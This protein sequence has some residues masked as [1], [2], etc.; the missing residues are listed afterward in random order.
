MTR[1]LAAFHVF[2]AV[3]GLLAALDP[4]STG[5]VRWSMAALSACVLACA[6]IVTR[7]GPRWPRNAFH[8]AVGSVSGLI[9]V[10]VLISPDPPPPRA[11]RPAGQ[12]AALARTGCA[13]S[14]GRFHGRPGAIAGLLAAPGVLLGDGVDRPG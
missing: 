1:T 6:G 10:A 8:V 9:V 3:A 12:A 13:F 5:R 14:Q 7:W 4:G 11:S 2:A